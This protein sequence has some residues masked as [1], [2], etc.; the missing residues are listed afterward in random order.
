MNRHSA[1]TG[2]SAAL[3]NCLVKCG[4]GVPLSLIELSVCSTCSR[5]PRNSD[6]RF[7]HVR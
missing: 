2:S 4:A 1:P 3:T 6:R 7:G 5:R